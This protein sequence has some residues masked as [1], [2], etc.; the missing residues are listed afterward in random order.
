MPKT[1]TKDESLCRH[2]HVNAIADY[3]GIQPLCRLTVSKFSRE[4][5]C[6]WSIE[7]FLHF[8]S[9]SGTDRD[10]GDVEFYR[11]LGR[12]AADHPH[13]LLQL[14]HRKGVEFPDAVAKSCLESLARQVQ[15]LKE[16]LRKLRG[17]SM[18]P[19]PRCRERIRQIKSL[20]P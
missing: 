15:S 9:H 7:T 20:L 18:V 2:L 17:V 19:D 10:T 5:Q 4:L 1:I 16:E 6:G 8:L 13:D 11:M 3:Y 12:V 14:Q